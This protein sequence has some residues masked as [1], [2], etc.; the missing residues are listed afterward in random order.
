MTTPINSRRGLRT[1]LA[2]A[3]RRR[4]AEA[5]MERGLPAGLS[6]EEVLRSPAG[7]ARNLGLRRAV[8]TQT[9]KPM[10]PDMRVGDD[11]NFGAAES[12]RVRT[13]RKGGLAKAKPPAR[14]TKATRQVAR[15][16]KRSA[17]R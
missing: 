2:N 15:N 4:E 5:V 6:E 1:P 8:Q 11:Q 9:D 17:T 10:R 14:T 16:Q 13:M 3:A 7:Y 12:R